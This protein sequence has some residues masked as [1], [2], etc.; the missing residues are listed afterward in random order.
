MSSI[1]QFLAR[2]FQKTGETI[3]VHEGT[4]FSE[5]FNNLCMRVDEHNE[6]QERI[7]DALLEAV[8]TFNKDLVHDMAGMLLED[9]VD[10]SELKTFIEQY[11]LVLQW[12]GER[13]DSPFGKALGMMSRYILLLSFKER[14]YLKKIQEEYVKRCTDS[15]GETV[16]AA[17]DTERDMLSN[18]RVDVDAA[19]LR[20]TSV[21]TA[22]EMKEVEQEMKAVKTAL[23]EQFELVN[24]LLT[25]CD[26]KNTEQ[27]HLLESL[28]KIHR[29]HYT[30]CAEIC[31][32]MYSSVTEFITMTGI[33]RPRQFGP[34]PSGLNNSELDHKLAK[35]IK[36]EKIELGLLDENIEEALD[37]AEKNLTLEYGVAK[38]DPLVKS[39]GTEEV[40]A[41]WDFIAGDEDQMSFKAGQTIIISRENGASTEDVWVDGKMG[42]FTGKVPVTYLERASNSSIEGNFL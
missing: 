24:D 40:V 33:R 28:C 5:E 35:I 23:G 38:F 11:G 6:W 25:E 26:R 30:E 17:I 18:R 13:I 31:D 8:D 37:E 14:D 1:T 22:E 41:L 4:A 20:Y 16:I 34:R 42:K 12:A 39:G 27:I 7:C 36:Q 9:L 2:I 21:N 29:D 32:K 3:G 19:K 10:S 15:R